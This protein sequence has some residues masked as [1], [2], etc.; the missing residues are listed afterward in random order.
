MLI[1]SLVQAIQAQ[2][3]MSELEKVSC[4][5]ESADANAIEAVPVCDDGR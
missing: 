4:G 2:P 3:C 5:K 1:A